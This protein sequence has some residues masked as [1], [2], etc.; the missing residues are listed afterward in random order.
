MYFRWT[1][2]PAVSADARH[3]QAKPVRRYGGTIPYDQIRIDFGT[4]F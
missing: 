2:V 4:K 3:V 1:E